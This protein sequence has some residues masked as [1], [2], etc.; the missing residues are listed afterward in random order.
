MS[1]KVVSA[2]GNEK[3][4]WLNRSIFVGDNLDVLRGMNSASVDLI[5]LDPPFNSNRNYSAPVGSEAAGA[6]FKDMWH[7]DDIDESW[8]GVI[9]DHYPVV[10]SICQM[11]EL[12]HSKGMKSYLAFMAIRIMELHR[13]LRATGSFYLHVGPTASHYL[14]LI[15]DAIFGKDNYRNELVWYYKNASRGIKQHA[16]AHDI[17]LLY[18]KNEKVGGVFNRD[19]V[20][21]PYESGVTAWRYQRAGK[22]PPKG[23]TPDDVL[24][25]P[26]LNTMAKER[27]GYPTQKPLA[28]LD[29]I[30]KASS[31][32][33]DI[34]LDPFCG[35]ATTCE[36]AERLG[37]QWVGIDLSE[38]ASDVI[39]MRLQRAVDEG[40]LFKGGKLP[41]VIV[42]SDVPIRDDSFESVDC[43]R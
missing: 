21:I 25:L 38:L 6:G 5:Y 10:Y 4:N 31:N 1:V 7:L 29:H 9:A 27:C 19:D 39:R 33:G 15:L 24:V 36:A 32:V 23:K 20:L 34:V 16:K 26:S 14:K 30:I 18:L 22:E 8:L 41:E 3:P 43:Q 11:S 35:C 37:R 13:I 28:L 2:V 12:T 42:R 17:L 40:A